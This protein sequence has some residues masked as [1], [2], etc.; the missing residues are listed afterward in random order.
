[1]SDRN[2]LQNTRGSSV[3]QSVPLCPK[4]TLTSVLTQDLFPTMSFESSMERVSLC[5]WYDKYR[6]EPW[7]RSIKVSQ[8][9]ADKTVYIQDHQ[10]I[11]D[12]LCMVTCYQCCWLFSK[13]NAK[14]FSQAECWLLWKQTAEM[15]YFIRQS[16][17]YLTVFKGSRG[18]FLFEWPLLISSSWQRRISVTSIWVQIS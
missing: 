14:L 5:C 4:Y 10:K 16:H 15:W 17:V 9:T 2:P 1:M 13:A 8:S 11:K 3:C 18:Q 12:A 6:A 7:E